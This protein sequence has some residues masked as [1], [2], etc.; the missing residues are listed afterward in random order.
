[1]IRKKFRKVEL[2]I[3]D[4]ISSER[5]EIIGVTF[6]KKNGKY[7]IKYLEPNNDEVKTISGGKQYVETLF[8]SSNRNLKE[9][10]I[11]K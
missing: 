8:S 2:K 4:V 10:L 5:C 11:N 6:N 7:Y 1:M 3:S 9:L